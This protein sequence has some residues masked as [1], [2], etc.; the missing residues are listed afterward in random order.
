MIGR[1]ADGHPPASRD[2]ATGA[3]A[4]DVQ[5]SDDR[6]EAT[7]LA[8]DASRCARLVAD[9]LVAEAVPAPAEV[10]LTF[11]D[12]SA[13]ADL[14]RAHLG[15]Q[16]PTDV[17]SFPLWEPDEVLPAGMVALLGDIVVC[18]AVAARYAVEHGR[19]PAD[20]LALLVVHGALHLVGHDHAEADEAAVM[21]ARELAHLHAFFDAAFAR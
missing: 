3:P 7:E 16:G 17:L 20:E 13:M 4:V 2:P 12:E 18:P 8:L 14:N 6:T 11:V 1:R 10:T 5:L 21:Q 9:T 15:E 19:R